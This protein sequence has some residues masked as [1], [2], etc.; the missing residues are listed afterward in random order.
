[1]R[2]TWENGEKLN[3]GSNFGPP[4]F[5]V[6]FTAS[7]SYIV[8]QAMII[9]YHIQLKGNPM[10]K[11]LDNMAKKLISS[12]IFTRLTQMRQFFFIILAVLVVRHYSKLLSYAI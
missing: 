4:I 7:S 8:F 2:H 11:K 9:S 3:F 1:M 6:T 5:F 10:T 12:T